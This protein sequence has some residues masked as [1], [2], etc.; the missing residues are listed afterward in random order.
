MRNEGRVMR[1]EGWGMTLKA[2]GG[3][4]HPNCQVL[5]NNLADK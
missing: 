2:L 5:A 1:D 4:F 3:V